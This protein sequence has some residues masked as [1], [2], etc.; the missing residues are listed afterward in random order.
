MKRLRTRKNVHGRRGRGNRCGHD[1]RRFIRPAVKDTL[2]PFIRM[3]QGALRRAVLP[4]IESTLPFRWNHA[5]RSERAEAC[6]AVGIVA[7]GRTDIASGRIGRPS[8]KDRRRFDGL[9]I[10]R[11]LAPLA[12]VSESR[13]E[14]VIATFTDWGWLHFKTAKPGRRKARRG[15]IR[16]AAQPIDREDGRFKGRAAVRVWTEK[17]WRDLGLWAALAEAQQKRKQAA[18]AARANLAPALDGLVDRL[19]DTLAAETPD[20]RERPPP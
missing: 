18:A 7:L 19:V 8:K 9:T 3:S 12:E 4:L 11:E 17:F 2:P 15:F 20:R 6:K 16:R 1:P 14:R 5:P 13:V 10:D